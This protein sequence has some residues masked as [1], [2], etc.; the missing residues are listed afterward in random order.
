MMIFGPLVWATTSPETVTLESASNVAVTLPLVIPGLVLEL[1]DDDLRALGVGHDLA[2]NRDRGKG[3]ERRGDRRAINEQDGRK[4]D[5]SSWLT[6]ELLDLD[7]VTLG[8]LVLLAAGLDDRVHAGRAFLPVVM[9]VCSR[10]GGLLF[11]LVCPLRCTGASPGVQANVMV[12][13]SENPTRRTQRSSI[14]LNQQANQG[15][16]KPAAQQRADRLQYAAGACLG[17]PDPH[18]PAHPAGVSAG[19]V[20][21]TASPAAGPAGLDAARRRRGGVAGAVG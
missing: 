6:L 5:G 15:I 20:T 13:P 17:K 9:P 12:T 7:D 3:V 18:R 21:T 4:G 10:F 11:V 1:V 8:D 16:A 14:R 19:R 2:G